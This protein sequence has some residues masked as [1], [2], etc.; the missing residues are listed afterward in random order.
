[1][2]CVSVLLTSSEWGRIQQA[3][4]EQ[5]LAGIEALKGFRTRIGSG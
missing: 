1:M 3:A 2:L 5:A 4:K